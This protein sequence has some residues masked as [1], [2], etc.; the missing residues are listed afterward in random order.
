[1]EYFLED[2]SAASAVTQNDVLMNNFQIY[3]LTVDKLKLELNNMALPKTG[4]KKNSQDFLKR[5]TEDMI[6]ISNI[7][8]TSVAT[9]GL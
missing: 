5:A 9:N 8:T 4:L 1:M 7:A 6:L 2:V 3:S